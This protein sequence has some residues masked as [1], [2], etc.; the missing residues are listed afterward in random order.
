MTAGPLDVKQ[1]LDCVYETTE[2]V[3][4]DS[5]GWKRA[6]QDDGFSA[7]QTQLSVFRKRHLELEA[8]PEV[9]NDQPSVDQVKLCFPKRQ[10]VPPM[11]KLFRCSA[12][13]A[14]PL[15]APPRVLSLP[16]PS[17]VPRGVR[18]LASAPSSA[19]T[20][21]PVLGGALAARGPRTRSEHRLA[22]LAR[23]RP[24]GA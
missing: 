17:G 5:F 19:S 24:P 1:L 7:R 20:V 8:S 16:P 23:S 3:V 10:K 21:R 14:L 2:Y 18:L 15:A 22:A 13:Q 6:F 4:E 12:M 11:T 9:G